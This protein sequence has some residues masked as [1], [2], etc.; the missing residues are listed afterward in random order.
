MLRSLDIRNF[1]IIE[2][3]HLDFD[4]NLNII[5]GE[6]GAGKSILMGALGLVL[7]KRADTTVLRDKAQKCTVEAVFDIT[8]YGL[9]QFFSENDLDYEDQTVIRREINPA[10]KSRAFINDIPVTLDILQALTSQ[11]VD[12]HAQ[13]ESQHLLQPAFYLRILDNL[14]GQQE[15]VNV[16]RDDFILLRNK[17]AEL[18]L[19]QEEAARAKQEQDF[20]QFQYDELLA[21]NLDEPSLDTLEQDL[22]LLENAETIKANI[23]QVRTMLEDSE[24][25]VSNQLR[26][27]MRLLQPIQECSEDIRQAKTTME[28]WLLQLR[29]MLRTLGQVADSA[30]YNPERIQLLTEQ[31]NTIN[32]LLQKHQVMSIEDLILLRD[33]MD[34]RLGNM[35]NTTARISALQDEIQQIRASCYLQAQ[36][37]SAVRRKLI[38][39]LET[40]VGEILQELGMPY[41]KVQW[42][43]TVSGPDKLTSSGIDNIDLYFSPN[44]G[45]TPQ[46]LDH[47]GSGGEKSRLML[48]IKAIVAGSMALPTLVFDEIDTGVSGAIA[49][50]MGDIFRRLAAHHQIISITHLPQVAAKGHRHF[51]VYKLHDKAVTYTEIRPITGEER[52]LEIAKM[53]SGEQPGAAALQTAKE[54]ME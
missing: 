18:R 17:T 3:I 26:E 40:T 21:A 4:A 11:L 5:T 46:T 51:F 45:S 30:D 20:L 37:L 44:K 27:A 2:A 10:G 33:E 47:V 34:S 36:D 53:L 12:I 48:A 35:Q 8:A 38:P 16:Y 32:R 52:I 54:L 39:R 31:Q 23:E 42:Q 13:Q 1:A 15:T 19:L 14:A 22:E 41:A 43:G 6:T 49:G 50:K 25:A 29:E 9:T 7:G 28:E 24:I